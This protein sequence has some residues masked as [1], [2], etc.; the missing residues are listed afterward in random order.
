[1]ITALWTWRGQYF[2]YRRGDFLWTKQ[3]DY[4]GRFWGNDLYAPSGQYLGEMLQQRLFVRALK[5]EWQKQMTSP[6]SSEID[7]EKITAGWY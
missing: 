6:Y 2:G 7:Y 4:V 1:M 3:G 5:K